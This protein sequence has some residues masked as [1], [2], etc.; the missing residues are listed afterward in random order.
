LLRILNE[1]ESINAEN[2]EA[3][4]EQI[5]DLK[6]NINF[7]EKILGIKELINCI[8]TGSDRT[9]EIVKYLRIFS[10]LDEDTLKYVDIHQ[11]IESTLIIMLNQ[12]REQINIVK[13]FGNIPMVEC[14]PGE[15][16]QVFLNILVNAIQSIKST[17]TITI[18]TQLSPKFKNFISVSIKDTGLG[19]PE[20]IQ[21]KIFEPFYSTKP[22]GEGSGLGLSISLGIIEKHKGHIELISEESVGSEFIVHLPFNQYNRQ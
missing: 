10:R 14:F 21:Q 2:L 16:N 4:I 11:N 12:S 22:I 1:Y 18:K 3:T 20:K 7:D 19:I 13:E 8:K 6:R 9:T 5:N 15:I 17:G